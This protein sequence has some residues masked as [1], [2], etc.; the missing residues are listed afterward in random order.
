MLGYFLKFISPPRLF[1]AQ[2]ARQSRRLRSNSGSW[3]FTIETR[4]L[5]TISFF[6]R[7]LSV[8]MRPMVFENRLCERARIGH[9]QKQHQQHLQQI[10]S[11]PAAYRDEP[12]K[13]VGRRLNPL[14]EAE[15]AIQLARARQQRQK[16][17]A[18]KPTQKMRPTSEHEPAA[19]SP[20][21]VRV[22]GAEA[23]KRAVQVA[24]KPAK[25]GP[26]SE[27]EPAAAAPN[28]VRVA[29][30]EAE[31]AVADWVSRELA[32][33]SKEAEANTTELARALEAVEGL[34][35]VETEA[36]GRHAAVG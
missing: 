18:T 6:S 21:S 34:M 11:K 14:A 20:N 3:Q 10:W 12:V 28:S 15:R 2:A 32:S 16:Q 9:Q 5:K 13:Q 22:A 25:M 17:R 26:T 27:H 24:A 4:R 19:S 31:R 33:D 7:V 36:S 35:A 23:E 30:A 29:E 1:N 8:S